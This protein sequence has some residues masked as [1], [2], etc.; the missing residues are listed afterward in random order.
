[1]TCE[2]FLLI[3]ILALAD[4]PYESTLGFLGLAQSFVA[5]P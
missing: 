1:M 3:R 5:L 4:D 2:V